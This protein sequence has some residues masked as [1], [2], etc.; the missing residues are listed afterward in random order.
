[1][2]ADHGR[3]EVVARRLSS[4]YT[5]LRMEIA[6]TES[7]DWRDEMKRDEAVL[8]D[9]L[10]RLGVTNADLSQPTPGAWRTRPA[11]ER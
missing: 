5:D 7:E 10:H 8:L 4:A 6:D 9:V 1:M 11:N 2:A 3:L